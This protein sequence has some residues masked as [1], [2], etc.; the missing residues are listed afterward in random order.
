MNLQLGK[1]N[2]SG[3]PVYLQIIRNFKLLILLG[4]INNG[5]EIP[6]RR[7]L[8]AQLGV[9]P[10]TVQK[11]LAELEKEQLIHTPPNA[12][13]VVH[14]NQD[15]LTT[16]RAELLETQVTTMVDAAIGA[17][18]TQDELVAMISTDWEKRGAK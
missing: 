14:A 6:S 8:A 12:K 17:G 10:N 4:E 3:E 15:I 13:S 16:L 2:P 9:N 18:I 1:P 11:A 5:D 7:I